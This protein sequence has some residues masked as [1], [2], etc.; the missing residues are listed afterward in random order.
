MVGYYLLDDDYMTM[1]NKNS[2]AR[3]CNL[4]FKK[5]INYCDRYHPSRVCEKVDSDQPSLLINLS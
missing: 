3:M 2:V 1:E 4:K 5:V